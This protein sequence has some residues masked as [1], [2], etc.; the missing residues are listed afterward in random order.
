MVREAHTMTL[1][2]S[3]NK[4]ILI[5]EINYELEEKK[6]YPFF[7]SEEISRGCVRE[8]TCLKI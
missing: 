7:N 3:N 8:N 4:I 5:L 1:C 6:N 2:C